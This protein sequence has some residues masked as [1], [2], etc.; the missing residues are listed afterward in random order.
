MNLSA[1]ILFGFVFAIFLY[2][3]FPQIGLLESSIIFLSSILID[4][5]HYLYYLY[6]KR[7]YSL[8]KAYLFFIDNQKKFLMLPRTEREEYRGILVI[9]HGIEI[10]MVLILFGI[11]ASSLFFYIFVG[12]AFHLLLDVIFQPVYWNR[13]DRI[14]LIRDFYKFK[15][16]KVL[17]GN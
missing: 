5:D 12:F 6:K 2:L 3:I 4:I 7:D 14:S 13:L 17:R 9:F 10:L 16:L 15:K 11:F 8:K 1:H